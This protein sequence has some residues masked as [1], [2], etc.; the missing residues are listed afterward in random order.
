MI[1]NKLIFSGS[2]NVGEYGAQLIDELHPAMNSH[3]ENYY[4][5]WNENKCSK[6]K[7]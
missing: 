2:L 3:L 6:L 1:I 7:I 4:H 5:G